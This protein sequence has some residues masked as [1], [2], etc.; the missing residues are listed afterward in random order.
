MKLPNREQAIVKESKIKDYL[1]SDTHV[2]GKTKAAFFNSVGYSLNE[3]QK[4]QKD[5]TKVAFQ[6]DVNSE[7]TTE[8]G[9]KYTV[10]GVIESP[11]GKEINIR[12]V[13]IID[14]NKNIPYLITAYPR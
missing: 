10:D 4:L 14:K 11:S 1:L 3:W 12:T 6:Y 9:I 8:F 2:I 5:L 13:W 7:V